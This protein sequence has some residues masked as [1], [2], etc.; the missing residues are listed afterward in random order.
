MLLELERLVSGPL[1]KTNF[2]RSKAV[3]GK[4]MRKSI[5]VLKYIGLRIAEL[6]LKQLELD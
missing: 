6:D 2:D 5:L 3:I 1:F 4:L